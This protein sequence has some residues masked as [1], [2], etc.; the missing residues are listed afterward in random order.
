VSAG[1]IQIIDTCVLLNLLASG[2]IEGILGVAARACLVCSAVEKE[3]LYLRSENPKNPLEPVNLAP[4]IEAGLLRICQVEGPEEEVLYVDYSSLLDDGEAMSL[5]IAV[6]RGLDLATD[7]RKAR[8]L[9]LEATGEPM[10]L[11]STAEMVRRWAEQEDIA[12]ARLRTGL[13]QIQ[14]RARYQPGPTD[15][16]YQWWIDL[17]S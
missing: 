12:D 16:N 2:E 1:R 8:R 5:A 11:L 17:C 15:G 4:L 13:L 6:A 10:R 14:G 3:S 7:E 9:F